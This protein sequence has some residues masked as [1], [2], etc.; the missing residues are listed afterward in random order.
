[1]PEKNFYKHV[2]SFTKTHY[3]N[4]PVISF[5]ISK[6]L[7][8]HIAVIYWFARTADDIADEGNL[9]EEERLKQLGEFENNLTAA[10]NDNPRNDFEAALVDTIKG[11]KLTA[12]LFYNLL[13]AFKQ[14]VI[15]KRYKD[16]REVLDY[17]NHSANP[18]GRLILELF[19]IRKDE[20]FLLSD[21][22]CTALQLTNFYQDLYLDYQKGRIYLP[23]D[24]MQKFGV[25]EKTF[26]LKEN[27]LNLQN[28]LRHNIGRTEEMFEEGKELLKHLKG[29]L[30]FEIRWTILGGERILE[31]IKETNY[32]TINIRPELSR[33]DY[34]FLAIKAL[35][36]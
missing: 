23:Y 18:V 1:M 35:F 7:Q 29:R 26:E 14:D 13:K 19:N 15:K 22:I 12:T 24:E 16:F 6:E 30:K 3:E 21:K 33:T 5:F 11:E 17:C 28:L 8:K 31:K 34:I 9:P 25:S 2:I 20:C 27:S 10:I 32:N 4:F 36:V